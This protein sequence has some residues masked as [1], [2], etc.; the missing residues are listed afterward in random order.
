M[1]KK[2]PTTKIKVTKV[3]KNPRVDAKPNGKAP[4]IS[5]DALKADTSIT[6]KG[7]REK[8]GPKTK[9]LA[10]VP[11]KGTISLKALQAKAE[12]E[13]LKAAAVPRFVKTVL[14]SFAGSSGV[15]GLRPPMGAAFRTL[16]AQGVFRSPSVTNAP[17]QCRHFVIQSEWVKII[18]SH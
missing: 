7:E 11:R 9:L 17:Q 18:R 14:T 1:A 16:A 2:Q 10:L 6:F 15:S 12:G 13:G 4:T 5:G 8:K 3:N